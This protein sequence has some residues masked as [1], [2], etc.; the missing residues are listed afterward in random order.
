MIPG[1]PNVFLVPTGSDRMLLMLHGLPIETTR[2]DRDATLVVVSAPASELASEPPPL[3]Q[4]ADLERLDTH[5]AIVDAPGG[6]RHFVVSVDP[7]V[8]EP[9][10]LCHP[11][12]ATQAVLIKM[13]KHPAALSNKRPRSTE[14][15]VEEHQADLFGPD[16]DGQQTD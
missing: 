2:C 3:M 16:H 12:Q 8:G 1:H 7:A 6:W 4:R 15:E 10:W 5:L 13:G 9:K 14:P 11:G